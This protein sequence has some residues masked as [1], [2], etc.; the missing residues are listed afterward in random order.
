MTQ[1]QTDEELLAPNN[2]IAIPLSKKV[3]AHLRI[4]RC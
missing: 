3:H 4:V 2:R 1:V